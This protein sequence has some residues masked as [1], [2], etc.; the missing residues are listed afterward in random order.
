RATSATPG[1]LLAHQPGLMLAGRR[2]CRENLTS[3]AGSA[4]KDVLARSRSSSH[5]HDD[6]LIDVAWRAPAELPAAHRGLRRG[7]GRHRGRPGLVCLA[8]SLVARGAGRARPSTAGA[9]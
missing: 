9:L 1:I 7:L 8:G 6:Q 5:G 2:N 4:K 3:A